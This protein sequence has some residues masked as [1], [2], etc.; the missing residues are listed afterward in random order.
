MILLMNKFGSNRSP[1]F[2]AC[3]LLILAILPGQLIFSQVSISPGTWITLKEGGT[4]MIGTDLHIKSVADSSGYF[5]D[6]TIDGDVTITGDIAVDR[7]LAPDIWHNVASPVSNETSDVF[8]GTDLV[9]WYDETQIWNDWNFGWVWYTG[10]TGGPLMVFR[11]YDVLFYTNP[12]TVVYSATGSETLNTGPYTYDITITDPAPNPIEIPSHMGWNFAG[13][14]YPCPVD[15]LASSGWDKS[16]INDAKYIWDGADSIYTIF[17]GGASPIGINGG[18][19]FIPS[20]QGFW[21]QAVVNGTIGINNST[22]LG[23]MTGTPDFYKLEPPDYPLVSLVASGNDR[24]DEVLVRFIEG[25]T[26]LF[27][28]NYDASKLYSFSENVPQLA[29]IAGKQ[30]LAVNT[31]PEMTD[32]LVVPIEFKCGKAGFYQLS[33]SDRTNLDQSV[34]LYLEDLHHATIFNLSEARFC[35]IFHDPSYAGDRFLLHFNPSDEF[36]NHGD[37]SNFSVYTERNMV[38]ITRNTTECITGHIC[39]FAITGQKIQEEFLDNSQINSFSVQAPTGYYIL[40]IITNQYVY[41]KKILII[42]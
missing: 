6:Q 18:T 22:R 24:S 30:H 10:A 9:F 12:V 35:T 36:L 34:K 1:A 3:A 37:E 7:Y 2:I 20:N 32:D 26:G 23:N 17:I 31:L 11:G 4:L 13:N 8:T 41:N 21:V 27:D 42:N 39:I 33:L 28:L 38:H 5:V 40:Y 16:D 19:R 14:P 15:W 29:I 25:T